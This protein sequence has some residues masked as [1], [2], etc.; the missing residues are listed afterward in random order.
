MFDMC[1]IRNKS[2]NRKLK[3][4]FDVSLAF[5][6]LILLIPIFIFISILIKL[7]DGGPILFW[8]KRYGQN[9]IFFWMPKFRSM[10]TDT[11]LID[12]KS[13]KNQNTYVT[14]VGKF[15]RMTSLDELPQF[16]CVLSGKMSLVGPR[17]ALCT[18]KDLI[19]LRDKKSINL[20]KP[21][22]TGHAQINGRD[23]ISLTKKVSLEV[24]YMENHDICFDI[25]I[26]LITIFGLRWLKDISH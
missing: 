3:R 22:I 21:G 15:L 4:V 26:L 1:L 23:N 10:S 6:L 5:F 24:E 2:V 9:K 17:P 12:T 13:L 7:D 20:L 14:V 8:S 11:P 18:Q 19:E 25:K 16:L